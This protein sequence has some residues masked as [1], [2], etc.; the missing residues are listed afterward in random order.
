MLVLSRKRNERII[1]GDVTI[2]VADIRG[3]KV[4]LGIEAPKCVPV[5]RAEI[6]E[7]LGTVADPRAVALERIAEIARSVHM[8]ADPWSALED[9]E[10][11]VAE[12]TG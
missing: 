8:G 11:Q 5:H 6:A 3:D 12:V 10:A 1:A 2:V 7:Q 9:I 4:R